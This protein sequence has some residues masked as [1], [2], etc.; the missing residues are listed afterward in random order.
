[1]PKK[2]KNSENPYTVARD[3]ATEPTDLTDGGQ[4]S[5]CGGCCSSVLPLGDEDIAR[6]RSFI[7]DT[8]F[9]P[10]LPDGHDVIYMHCPFLVEDKTAGTK[11]CAAYDVR[12]GVCRV[13]I[14]SNSNAANAK[15][16]ADA[17]G[18]A[19]VPS[20]KNP[21]MLFNRTGLRL[22]G[23]EIPY[24]KAPLCRIKNDKNESYE[25]HVGR[26]VSLMLEDGTYVPPSIVIGIYRNGLHVFNGAKH[27][28]EFIPFDIMTDV[29]SEECHADAVRDLPKG[30]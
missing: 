20:P 16:W 8:G 5:R 7:A 24:D 29:L 23:R 15:A 10:S 14:C 22:G 11:S 26:P 30:E 1:M 21:W 4:C 18:D 28:M 3:L 2:K 12:P 17:Y 19:E 9:E 27:G 25:F 6:L 13:F